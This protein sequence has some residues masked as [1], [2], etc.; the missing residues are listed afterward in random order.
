MGKHSRQESVPLEPSPKEAGVPFETDYAQAQTVNASEFDGLVINPDG[1][2]FDSTDQQPL[3]DAA[4]TSS[5]RTT[6]KNSEA[7][8][9]S[10]N[11]PEESRS[12]VEAEALR[13]ALARSIAKETAERKARE[14]VEEAHRTNTA[15]TEA[16][17]ARVAQELVDANQVAQEAQQRADAAEAERA[18]LV[19]KE[20]D[21][22][23]AEATERQRQQDLASQGEAEQR[24]RAAERPQSPMEQDAA[25]I[26]AAVAFRAYRDP[27]TSASN[28]ARSLGLQSRSQAEIDAIASPTLRQRAHDEEA[29]KRR[30]I[31]ATLQELVK[32]GIA[33]SQDKGTD[34]DIINGND[35]SAIAAKFMTTDE[36]L[37]SKPYAKAGALNIQAERTRKIEKI[38]GTRPSNNFLASFAAAD[39]ANIVYD[40]TGKVLT[41]NSNGGLEGDNVY[42]FREVAERRPILETNKQQE[43]REIAEAIDGD[44]RIAVATITVPGTLLNWHSWRRDKV[45]SRA[46]KGAADKLA[47]VW[48]PDYAVVL[49]N[50]LDDVDSDIKHEDL[51]RRKLAWTERK[52]TDPGHHDADRYRSVKDRYADTIN[53]E[54]ARPETTLHRAGLLRE[55]LANLVYLDAMYGAKGTNFGK[56]YD[57]VKNMMAVTVEEEL[58]E[59]QSRYDYLPGG[60]KYERL[61]AKLMLPLSHLHRSHKS[62]ETPADRRKLE[63]Q[64]RGNL[65]TNGMELEREWVSESFIKAFHDLEKRR[66]PA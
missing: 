17:A 2:F 4:H 65:R 23:A 30:L 12:R 49:A 28:L 58:D 53:G 63:R 21:R 19:Q 10:S 22:L 66:Q 34:R 6:T 54:L 7:G 39:R 13:A 47:D 20:R 62:K 11:E 32:Q 25:G 36:C 52:H 18:R 38:A 43:L 41:I 33:T 61:A 5:E 60:D 48:G 29:T 44:V 27:V 57:S 3:H 15:E 9:E 37:T 45:T 42:R 46:G 8:P 40:N 16:E 1:T 14:A 31:W 64:D 24:R 56:R 50:E 51:L 55:K 35:T 59:M 26:I